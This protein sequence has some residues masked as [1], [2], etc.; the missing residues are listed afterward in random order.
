LVTMTILCHCSPLVQTRKR[1]NNH[2][3]SEYGCFLMLG[4]IL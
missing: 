1:H 2:R 4:T 3:L